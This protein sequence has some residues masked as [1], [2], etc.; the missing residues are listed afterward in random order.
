VK[1]ASPKKPPPLGEPQNGAEDPR[2]AARSELERVA[3]GPASSGRARL[4]KVTALRTLERVS[5]GRNV[6]PPCPEGWHPGPPELEELDQVYLEDRPEVR[7]RMWRAFH[8][9]LR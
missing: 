5:R 3:L 2:E 1:E 8:G 6:I 9:R 7:E 4:A